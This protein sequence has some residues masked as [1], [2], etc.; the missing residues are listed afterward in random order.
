ML[1]IY[2]PNLQ[3]FHESFAGTLSPLQKLHNTC[4]TKP[5]HHILFCIHNQE[6][7]GQLKGGWEGDK[8]YVQKS[9]IMNHT[10]SLFSY[11]P[12]PSSPPP[13]TSP[14]HLLSHLSLPFFFHQAILGQ[15]VDRHLLGLKLL[16]AEAGMETPT[17]FNDVA[18]TRSLHFRLSTSQVP[19]PEADPEQSF[20]HVITL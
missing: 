14:S 8:Q 4:I 7:N 19:M 20:V 5:V 3:Q 6:G 12:L 15:A 1:K 10:T 16:A 11:I 2:S 9:N 13:P 18:Y 17:I